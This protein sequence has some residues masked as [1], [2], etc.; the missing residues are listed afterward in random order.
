MTG[1]HLLLPSLGVGLAGLIFGVFWIPTRYLEAN[2]FGGG[3]AS[4][5]IFGVA[6]VALL[7]VAPL[8]WRSLAINWRPILLG[9]VFTGLG[10][11]LYANALLLTDVVRTLLLFYLTPVWGTIFG[12]LMLKERLTGNRIAALLLGLSGSLVILGFEQG[13]PLPHN[14]GDWMALG[15]GLAWAYGC[16]EL[17]RAKSTWVWEAT[18]SMTV[19]ATVSS[20]LIIALL[21]LDGPLPPPPAWDPKVFA[22]G[23]IFAIAVNLP[24]LV[25]T[26]WG[27]GL[28][29]PGRVGI[30]LCGEI[31]FGIFT[32]VWL[33][34][35]PFGGAEILGA[36]L[37]IGAVAAEMATKPP[38]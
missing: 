27:A 9:G 37:I 25:L 34:D 2:G 14:L 1:R 33:T 30:L 24:A 36:L 13:L 19:G 16:L 5:F 12:V 3:L 15:G 35:E 4:L 23:L 26:M 18:L 7:P 11:A 28:L 8:R 6:A 38:R 29:S 31:A 10:F 20:A 32:A 17:A 21:T 22:A